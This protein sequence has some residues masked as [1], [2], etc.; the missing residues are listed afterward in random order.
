MASKLVEKVFIKPSS[1]TPESLRHYNLSSYDQLM[2]EYYISCML[3]YPNPHHEIST[4]CLQLKNSLSKTLVPYYPLAGRLVK[5]DYIDCNDQGIEFIQVRIHCQLD[6]FL[7]KTRFYA[8]DQNLLCGSAEDSLV[9]VQLS[10]FDCGGV[11]IAVSIS[12]KVADG[13]AAAA[14]MN[15]WALS[16]RLSS[17]MPTP[18]LVSDS[19]FPPGNNVISRPFVPCHNCVMRRFLFPVED[20]EKLKTKAIESGILGPTKVEVVIALLYQCATVAKR[21]SRNGFSR[22]SV[23]SQT[24]NLRPSLK[25]PQNAIGNMFSLHFCFVEDDKMEIPA[26]IGEI[27][28]AKLKLR[29]LPYE[30]QMKELGE[31]LEKLDPNTVDIYVFSSLCGFPI[32]DIDFGW[33]KPTRVQAF[34]NEINNQ[35]FLMDSP[36][37]GIEAFVILE[38]EMI[39]AFENNELL[40]P[41]TSLDSIKLKSKI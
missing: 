27:R 19:L 15:D 17:H 34:Q 29:K 9:V 2:P 25:L 11:A 4:I 22:T 28:K 7:K 3:F 41:F 16:T 8:A 23:L 35:I 13:S 18:L 14:F 30:S 1:P 10:H 6:S 33:G 21:S 40:L 39:S 32:Y 12:H 36:Q 26:L 38:E 24:V 20:I 37:D 31:S 5:N